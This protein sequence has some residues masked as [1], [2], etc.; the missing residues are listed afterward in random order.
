VET[1]VNIRT[2][3][4]HIRKE[5]NKKTLAFQRKGKSGQSAGNQN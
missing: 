1:Q 2:T 5:K 4:Q 3:G